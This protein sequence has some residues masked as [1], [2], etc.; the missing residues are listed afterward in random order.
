MNFQ[1]T[2]RLKKLWEEEQHKF[3]KQ[4]KDALTYVGQL[5]ELDFETKASN[6]M[7]AAEDLI[8]RGNSHWF[9]KHTGP[10]RT[11]LNKMLR[12][13]DDA[14]SKLSLSVGELKKWHE[15]WQNVIDEANAVEAPL[16]KTSQE[17]NT[18]SK[19]S[20][21]ASAPGVKMGAEYFKERKTKHENGK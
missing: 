5:R 8:S 9:D 21:N 15:T 16:T 11:A 12:A 13:G 7:A 1:N 17:D 2:K 18:S 3:E 6:A 10:H 4:R 20:A 14:V 19:F